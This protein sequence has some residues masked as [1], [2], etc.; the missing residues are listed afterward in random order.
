MVKVRIAPLN[1]SLLAWNVAYRPVFPSLFLPS[2]LPPSSHLSGL[3]LISPLSYH[4]I[5]TPLCR[6]SYA[7]GTTPP[8]KQ[9]RAR[10]ITATMPRPNNRYNNPNYTGCCCPQG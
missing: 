6:S 7:R 8:I 1:F 10:V 2:F 3:H 9:P 4:T 5:L